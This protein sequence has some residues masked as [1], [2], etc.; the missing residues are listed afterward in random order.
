ILALRLGS[1][2]DAALASRRPC[3]AQIEPG[4]VRPERA[5]SYYVPDIAVT[6]EPNE[7]GRQAMIDPILVIEILSPSTERSDRRLKLPVYQNIRSVREIMLIDADSY[8]AELY[9][10]ENDHWGIQ[11]V[12]GAEAALPLVSVDLRISMS[13][14]YEGIPISASPVES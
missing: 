4:V 10:R 8:H 1:R 14:V 12:R 11:L 5:D 7:P 13:E 6:C 3:N 2:I 9:R